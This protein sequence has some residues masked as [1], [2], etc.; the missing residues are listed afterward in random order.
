MNEIK[1]GRKKERKVI[2][3]SLDSVS[4]GSLEYNLASIPV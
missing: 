4:C 1:G 3:G 2:V